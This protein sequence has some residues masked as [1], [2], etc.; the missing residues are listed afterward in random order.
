MQF[1][2][3]QKS[4]AVSRFDGPQQTVEI[5]NLGDTQAVEAYNCRYTPTGVGCRY[6]WFGRYPTSIAPSV[7]GSYIFQFWNWIGSNFNRLVMLMSSPATGLPILRITTSADERTVYSFASAAEG[8]ATSTFGGSLY[9]GTY[10]FNASGG[11]PQPAGVESI[12]VAQDPISPATIVA[13]PLWPGPGS[14]GAPTQTSTVITATTA[15]AA[16]GGQVSAGV[17][18]FTAV[19]TT[20]TGYVFQPLQVSPLV[21]NQ[22]LTASGTQNYTV[23]FNVAAGLAGTYSKLQFAM[24]PANETINGRYFIIPNASNSYLVTAAGIA[25]GVLQVGVNDEDLIATGINIVEYQ[26]NFYQGQT[27]QG[28]AVTLR[29]YIIKAWGERMVYGAQIAS[30]SLPGSNLTESA[31][32]ISDPGL[33]QTIALARSIYQ[34]PSAR[35]ITAVLPLR[36]FAYIFGPTYTYIAYEG[37]GDPV[38]WPESQQVDSQLGALSDRCVALNS[39]KGYVWVVNQ[40]GLWL[41][42]GSSYPQ[43][44]ISFYCS[45]WSLIDWGYPRAISVVDNYVNQ[46]VMVRVTL[47]DSSTVVFVFDYQNGITP[48]A[49]RYSKWEGENQSSLGTLGYTGYLGTLVDN[50]TGRV[51]VARS[52]VNQT[53][54]PKQGVIDTLKSY[55]PNVYYADQFTDQLYAAPSTIATYPIT[56]SYEHAPL[57][58]DNWTPVKF[59]GIELAISTPGGTVTPSVKDKGG[60]RTTTL[61]AIS[62]EPAAPEQSVV[63]MFSVQSEGLRVRLDA[64]GGWVL[65]KLSVFNGGPLSFRR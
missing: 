58:A 32:F 51:S 31:L 57:P 20:R 42:I 38:T 18:Y 7:S 22:Y 53:G 54:F 52:N 25:G 3:G 63:R 47:T 60:L 45:D 49:V 4:T 55:P 11:V 40:T 17:H 8:M 5:P 41:L 48:E 33:P 44:P 50:A 26:Q 10:N 56:S 24:T 37:S 28:V 27:V 43:K 16:T 36:D 35:P 14:S 29:P 62:S 59:N 13:D 61:T 34:L 21:A 23:Q 9:V 15:V 64:L 12:I 1:L 2:A 65:H 19:F 6:G 30:S 39:S 46:Q